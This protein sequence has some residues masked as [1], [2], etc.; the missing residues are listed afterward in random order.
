MDL[1]LFSLSFVASFEP[2]DVGNAFSDPN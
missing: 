2:Q 1:S